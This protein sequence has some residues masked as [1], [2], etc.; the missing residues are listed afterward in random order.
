MIS[1]PNQNILIAG[2]NNGHLN[3]IFEIFNIKTGIFKEYKLPAK[4]SQ[5][6]N[7]L[8][9]P[10][11]NILINDSFIYDYNTNKYINIF[12]KKDYTNYSASFI[13]SQNEIFILEDDKK[14]YLYNYTDNSLREI[15]IQF[16]PKLV[17]KNFIKMDND[18]I[19]VYGIHTFNHQFGAYFKTDI[20]LWN[21]KNNVFTK[22]NINNISAGASIVKINN[23]EIII[24]GEK[25]YNQSE[26]NIGEKKQE[27][28][29][30]NI[31]TNVLTKLKNSIISR[32][33]APIVLKLSDNKIFL[34]GGENDKEKG[35][36]IA[37]LYNP[38]KDEYFKLSSITSLYI[39]TR[40]FCKPALLELSNK[41][42][43][44]CGGV[45]ESQVQDKCLIF[46]MGE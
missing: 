26:N 43:L 38:L 24:F 10:N 41:D 8:L 1:L 32:T 28:Y 35:N 45:W 27:T 14:S 44:I 40:Q 23:D 18:N 25:F 9:L 39:P 46:K 11:N 22:L 5:P 33:N 36:M 3:G 2:G 6:R 29:K 17:G 42:I 7:S 20:Y 34:I 15:D 30:L 31:R 13:Y 4:Y 21:I 19:V 12:K 37:E 16:P